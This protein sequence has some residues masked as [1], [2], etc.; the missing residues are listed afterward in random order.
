MENVNF[1]KPRA[2]EEN[3]INAKVITPNDDGHYFFGY[4][5]L[6]PFDSTGRYHLCHKAP[7]EDRLPTENDICELGA[8]DLQTGEFIKYAETNA[9][10]FQ[11][12]TL[13]QWFKDDDH[14]IYNVRDSGAY[15]TCIKNIRTGETRLLP[16]AFANLSADCTKALC[17]NFSRIYDF[18]AGYGYAGIV[19]PYINDKAPKEDGVFLMDT[20]TGEVKQILDYVKLRDA[21]FNDTY[22]NGKLLVNHINFNP[23][24]N[25]FAMLFRNFR[26]PEAP[27]WR[28]QLLTA[29]LDGNIFELSTWGFHS[30]YHWK[31]DDQLLIFSAFDINNRQDGLWLFTDKTDKAEKLPE[32]NPKKDIHCFYSPNRRYIMGDGYPD[33]DGYRWLHFIDTKTNTDTILGKY[34]SY[35][36]TEKDMDYRCDLH[37]RF[38]P[39]GRYVSFDS[40]HTG[41]RSICLIDLSTLE[42]YEY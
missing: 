23:S 38:D 33:A 17:I 36:N 34:L 7:F 21:Y 40:I 3:G 11:Q 31:N 22:S 26:T 6:Q 32:P 29:D 35:I 4:Y 10:N 41:K 8:I 2:I 13:L 24:A 27:M 9:W 28:T 25:R 14:I 30:H 20:E 15:K 37:A 42:G 16:M 5:D 1:I 12:G 39:S 19:D 18:R